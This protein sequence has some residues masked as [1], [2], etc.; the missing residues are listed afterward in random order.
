MITINEFKSPKLNKSDKRFIN[1][2]LY[3]KTTGVYFNQIPLKGIMDILAKKGIILLQEDHTAW[4]GFLLGRKG[5]AY[6]EIAYKKYA[7]EEEDGFI[8]YLP[9]GDS[10]LVLQ[11]HKMD[12]GRYEIVTYL[13]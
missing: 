2:E 5:N 8:R 11:W 12:S 4:S 9:I 3:D 1:N 7:Y 13:S 10:N 6:F